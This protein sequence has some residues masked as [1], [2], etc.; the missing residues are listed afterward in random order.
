MR[1]TLVW[2]N[3]TSAVLRSCS[4]IRKLKIIFRLYLFSDGPPD[5]IRTDLSNVQRSTVTFNSQLAK[6]ST[7][8][9][10]FTTPPLKLHELQ[11]TLG[12]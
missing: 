11:D 7:S 4:V 8:F 9:I 2:M 3:H 12:M 10:F 5:R 6:A 1:W